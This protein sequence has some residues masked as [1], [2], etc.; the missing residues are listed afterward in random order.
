MLINDKN[1][2]VNEF[3]NE[4]DRYYIVTTITKNNRRLNNIK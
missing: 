3:P 1:Y 4:T 2:E